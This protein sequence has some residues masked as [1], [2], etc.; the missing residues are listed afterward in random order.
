[1]KNV[2]L[3]N[4]LK[5]ALELQ[6][7]PYSGVR[8]VK[9][10]T[11][12]A[13]DG[14]SLVAYKTNPYFLRGE[15][16]LHPL[17]TR[18]LAVYTDTAI[19]DL[20]VEGNAVTLTVWIDRD[21]TQTFNLPALFCEIKHTE[22]IFDKFHNATIVAEQLAARFILPADA[23]AFVKVAGG[24][25][26]PASDE[27]YPRYDVKK[28]KQCLKLFYAKDSVTLSVTEEGYLLGKDEWG[29]L[30]VVSPIVRNPYRQ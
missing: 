9:D 13:T 24:G 5:V 11:I 23:G 4:F 8:V 16:M 26:G 20:V 2:R 30:F 18:A 12:I 15:G 27:D 25:L 17:T 1:M 19:S 29:Q 22:R 6:E 7:L 3:R 21:N 10:A 28:L 14:Y